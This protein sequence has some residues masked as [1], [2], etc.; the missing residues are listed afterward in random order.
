MSLT[1]Q[2]GT[3][4]N[5]VGSHYWSALERR[6][7][8]SDV[9][10][11]YNECAHG[12]L[13]PRLFVVESPDEVGGGFGE[14]PESPSP[15]GEF[16][17]QVIERESGDTGIHPFRQA[18]LMGQEPVSLNYDS[19]G[20]WTD[21]WELRSLPSHMELSRAVGRDKYWFETKRD[22]DW[23]ETSLR[24][25]VEE[26][27]EAITTLQLLASMQDV[28]GGL[29]CSLF[30]YLRTS[31]PKSKCF[32]L[33]SPLPAMHHFGHDHSIP[34]VVNLAQ[35]TMSLLSDDTNCLIVAP[36]HRESDSSRIVNSGTEAVWLDSLRLLSCEVNSIE[37]IYLS[38]D[39]VSLYSPPHASGYGSI[40]PRSRESGFVKNVGNPVHVTPQ[41]DVAAGTYSESCIVPVLENAIPVVRRFVR[42]FKQVYA[43]YCEEGDFV[44]TV[45]FL[46]DRLSHLKPQTDD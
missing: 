7:D 2:V 34:A 36:P 15:G 11:N 28:S 9:A 3:H 5:W 18:L 45:E 32:S 46:S 25:L 38:I 43:E 20:Y 21:F 4:S 26:T 19:L 44:E 42:D 37:C 1:V 31:Y 41:S 35:F 29:S 33:V 12:N 6:S 40:T 24:R 39:G 27:D 30:E 14:E 13:T 22:Q 23:D 16:D 8:K 17:V 10:H